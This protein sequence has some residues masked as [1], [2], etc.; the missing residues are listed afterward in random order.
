MFY[1]NVKWYILNNSSGQVALVIY[2]EGL[3]TVFPMGL[4]INA[5]VSNLLRNW[6]RKQEREGSNF[7]LYALV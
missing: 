3:I 6:T 5:E 4:Y 1:L 7:C 2:S